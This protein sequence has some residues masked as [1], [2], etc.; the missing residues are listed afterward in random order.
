MWKASL[1]CNWPQCELIHILFTIVMWNHSHCYVK[2][3][4]LLCESIPIAATFQ[5]S[6]YVKPFRFIKPFHNYLCVFSISLPCVTN[7][8]VDMNNQ[9]Y[10]RQHYTRNLLYILLSGLRKANF[11]YSRLFNASFAYYVIKLSFPLKYSNNKTCLNI[12]NIIE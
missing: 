2:P 7:G 6:F 4:T 1:E 9:R 10:L 3:F 8:R 11:L 5:Q 12:R